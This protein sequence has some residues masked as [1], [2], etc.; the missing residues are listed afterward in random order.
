MPAG[1][2][3]VPLSHGTGRSDTARAIDGIGHYASTLSK[4]SIPDIP[5]GEHEYFWVVTGLS[6]KGDVDSN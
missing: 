4:W 5:G 1:K 6:R 2:V 3:I